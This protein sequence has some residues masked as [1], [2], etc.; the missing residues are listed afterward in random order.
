MGSLSN[1]ASLVN[2][3]LSLELYAGI[4]VVP[5]VGMTPP[6][7]GLSRVRPPFSYAASLVNN[8]LSHSHSG[9]LTLVW[10]DLNLTLGHE[11]SGHRPA[12][13]RK[14]VLWPGGAEA[15]H[16]TRRTQVKSV[17]SSSSYGFAIDFGVCA[18]LNRSQL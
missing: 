5:A 12:I 7:D 6:H 18:C 9:A 14:P 17:S 10:I 2:N 16:T 4:R 15:F 3:P 13:V 8:L 1:R 11:Q